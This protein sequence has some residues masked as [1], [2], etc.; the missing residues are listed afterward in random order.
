MRRR[1]GLLAALF[2][3][4][5]QH[6]LPP[7]RRAAV[8]EK[9]DPLPGAK[10]HAPRG[11]RNRKL[12]LRQRRSYMGG[13]VVGSLDAVDITPLVLRRDCF[14]KIFE[15]L[16]D[17]GIGVFLDEERCRGVAAENRQEAGRNI[18]VLE[19]KRDFAANINKAFAVGVNVQGMKRLAHYIV[20]VQPVL[21]RGINRRQKP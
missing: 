4:E 10:H 6:D 19:P 8:L 16:L 5:V 12:R 21:S 11:N 3:E 9:I 13:H 18:L 2:S 14:E 17:I 20:P 1:S 7:V 15:I